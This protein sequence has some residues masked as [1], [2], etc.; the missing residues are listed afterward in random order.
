MY[1]FMN[2][3]NERMNGWEVGRKKHRERLEQNES[4][5]DGGTE[6]EDRMPGRRRHEMD[7]TTGRS[8]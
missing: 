1:E 2:G 8:N 7:D 4:G 3:M 5:R 6:R